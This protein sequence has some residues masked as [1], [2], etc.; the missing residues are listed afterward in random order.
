MTD[1]RA[2]LLVNLATLIWAS[3]ITLGR[4]VRADIGPVTLTTVRIVIA[5]IIFA[6]I[7]R[8]EFGQGLFQD[9]RMLLLLAATGIV[10]FPIILYLSVRYTTAV[11]A[12]IITA[13]SPLVTLWLAS[14]MLQ[15]RFGPR[16]ALGMA[17]SLLGVAFIV[18]IDAITIGLNV[19][20]ALSVFDAA[21][22]ALYSVLGRIAMRHRGAIATTGAALI[23]SV[24][25][26]APLALIEWR[27]I[28]PVWTWQTAL[29]ALYIG[30]GPAAIALLAW[31][32]GVRAIG[33]A[34]AMAFYN[35]LPLYVALLALVMLG[36]PLRWTSV[37]GGA[38]VIGGGVLAAQP[39]ARKPVVG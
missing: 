11:N 6:F 28:P 20:D 3:N 16:H 22:W 10:G 21:V 7:L 1:R 8:R 35:T 17:L 24:P 14:W 32:S 27:Y 37:L 19:G 38:L 26:I 30:I 39:P 31:N 23:L 36:E 29:I 15:E 25:M 5:A 18:G 33:P 12:G 34:R 9:W 4:A 2:Y 13:I